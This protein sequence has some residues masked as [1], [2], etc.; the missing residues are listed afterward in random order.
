MPR[1]NA[2]SF[3]ETPGIETICRTVVGAGFDSL[4]LSRLPFFEKLTTARTRRAFAEWAE[5]LGLS[6]YGFACWVDVD[7]YVAFDET[8]EGF[9]GAVDFAA[10][11]DLGMI[12]SHDP[13]AKVNGDRSPA[14][15]LRTNVELFRRVA[16][17]TAEKRLRLVF[18]PHPDTLSMDNAWA[19]DFIDAVSEGHAPGTVGILYDCCHY[20]VGQPESYAPSI[21]ALGKRILHLHFS[22]GDGE[23]YA[24]HLPLGDGT[25][26]LAGVV[27]ELQKIGFDGTLTNDL[28]NYP[29][30]EEGARRNAPRILDVE[31]QLGLTSP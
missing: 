12:I 9:R 31:R 17:M 14:E 28:Y 24:L 11:L 18:E 23:S 1:V 7:P 6:L 2:V 3:H 29:L 19:V 13:W 30:L 22:D 25:L 8:L 20:G 21:A 27:A 15:C 26:D 5:R 4:E 16:D 10:D